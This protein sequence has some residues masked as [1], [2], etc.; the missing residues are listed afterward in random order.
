[1]EMRNSLLMMAQSFRPIK[2]KR[3][4]I[5]LKQQRHA[6]RRKDELEMNLKIDKLSEAFVDALL[7]WDLY[8]S[9]KCWHTAS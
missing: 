7:I 3:E 4:T 5:R 6:N 2:S 9:G 8:D 1:M